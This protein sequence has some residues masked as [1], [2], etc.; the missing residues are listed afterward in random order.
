M[1]SETLKTL[2][3]GVGD[4]NRGDEAIGQWICEQAAKL[5]LPN[6][7]VRPMKILT[8]DLLDQLQ[9]FSAVIIADIGKQKAGATLE[10]LDGSEDGYDS[11][12]YSDAVTLKA[13]HRNL[14]QQSIVWH[15]LAIKGAKFEKGAPLSK[16]VLANGA[17]GIKLLKQHLSKKV[18]DKD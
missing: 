7:H 10:E 12:H 2:L 13:L 9:N 11:Q 17:E 16:E 4:P 15:A 14:Y 6:L 8:I 1:A 5:K 3:I 18:E